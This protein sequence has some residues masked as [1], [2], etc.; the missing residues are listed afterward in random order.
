[1]MVHDAF[2]WGTRRFEMP[3]ETTIDAYNEWS[4]THEDIVAKFATALGTNVAAIVNREDRIAL[5]VLRGLSDVAPSPL[6]TVGFSGGGLR[7]IL[8]NA[9]SEEIGATAVIGMMST[10]RPMAPDWVTP[11]TW[12][13]WPEALAPAADLPAIAASRSPRPLL[14]HYG[15]YDP[16][17]PIEGRHEA[18]DLLAGLYGDAPD[19]YIGRAHAAGHEYSREMQEQ[20]ADWFGRVLRAGHSPAR[21]ATVE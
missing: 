7:A 18:H 13:L 17:F 8:L 20:T 4:I 14:V 21:G 9:T 11:H 16:M 15:E 5:G 10:L 12:M 19:A 3:G 1:M 2:M 6:G